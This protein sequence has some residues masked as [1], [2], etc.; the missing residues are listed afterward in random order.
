MEALQSMRNTADGDLRQE[1]KRHRS[2]IPNPVSSHCDLL[3]LNADCSKVVL[4]EI[5]E[6]AFSQMYNAVVG[7]NLA[8][9]MTKMR[10]SPMTPGATV[11]AP[12]SV[13]LYNC[14]TAVTW[15]GQ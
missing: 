14:G 4:L 5:G 9:A 7:L 13:N 8:S 1:F 10:I 11:I 6:R 15:K 3:K 2:S 12:C